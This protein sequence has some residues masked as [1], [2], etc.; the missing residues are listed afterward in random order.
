M[1]Q[2][3]LATLSTLVTLAAVSIPFLP[4]ATRA[5]ASRFAGVSIRR[6]VAVL[7]GSGTYAAVPTSYG[8]WVGSE[9]GLSVGISGTTAVVGCGCERAYIFADTVKGWKQVGKLKGSDTV[10]SDAFGWSAAISGDT[11]LV[12]AHERGSVY[13]FTRNAGR[14]LQ[15][16][17][18]QAPD[19]A[20]GTGFGQSVA[21]SG[22]TAIVGTSPTTEIING[23][24]TGLP[25]L[26][27]VF[28]EHGTVWQQT[29]VL[30]GSDT[31]VG[32][33]FASS[34]AIS[35]ATAIVGAPGHDNNAGR[36]YLFTQTAAG[37]KQAAELKGSDTVPGKDLHEAGSL[38]GSSVSLSGTTAVVGAPN[39]N[40]D[41]TAYVFEKTATGWKQTAEVVGAKP[42]VFFGR[43][44]AVSGNTAVVTGGTSAV[45][46]AITATG[47]RQ[48]AELEGPVK[49]GAF[50]AD[51][52]SISGGRALVGDP[53]DGSG[54]GDIFA[55]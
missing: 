31:V 20:H 33:Q 51:T 42:R 34:L 41:G 35:G 40:G 26:A 46:F 54:R 13:V 43:S 39:P 17:E 3:R 5:V 4:G 18:L 16:A 38:F 37:W 8:G 27:Y 24:W 45:V 55:A 23:R 32:D 22:T 11:V 36:A 7:K 52:V 49:D 47:W 10:A 14:W 50:N 48:A 1:R 25:A 21:I 44:V 15:T 9:F 12:G 29:A 53:Y 6:P 30:K 19:P 28:T 2:P